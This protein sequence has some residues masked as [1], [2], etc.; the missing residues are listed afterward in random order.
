[1]STASA[2]REGSLRYASW[3]FQR[4]WSRPSA[5]AVD[6]H[7]VRPHPSLLPSRSPHPSNTPTSDIETLHDFHALL[8]VATT[9]R[10]RGNVDHPPL[11]PTVLSLSTAA[12]YVKAQ[13]RPTSRPGRTLRH[14][15]VA[16]APRAGG[17]LARAG[18]R[19]QSL[20]AR[21]SRPERLLSTR[22]CARRCVRQWTGHSR[23]GR[24]FRYGAA[25]DLRP[26][27]EIAS[28]TK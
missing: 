7:A 28:R 17:R 11:D 23:D 26:D 20:A 19:R 2:V 3:I 18:R 9:A 22:S 24:L 8:R 27:P 1:M 6:G 21:R 16:P 5:C 12:S 4:P 25:L 13:I 15:G 10:S 14:A